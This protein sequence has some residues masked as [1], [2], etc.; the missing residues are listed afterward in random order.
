MIKS[1][2]KEKIDS[3]KTIADCKFGTNVKLISPYNIYDCEIGDNSFVGPF[4]EIQSGVKVG[5]NTTISS[6]TFV[7]SGVKI[8]NNCF[9]AHGVMF[10]NDKFS[11]NEEMLETLIEDNVKIG[12]NCTILPVKIGENSTIGAGSVVTKDI[13]KNSIVIGNPAKIIKKKG[14]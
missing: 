7:C 14:I 8:G 6:H 10:T 1:N 9:I 4:V 13:P 2:R 12:S 11:D 3:F 5:A